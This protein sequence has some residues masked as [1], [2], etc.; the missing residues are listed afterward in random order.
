MS[1]SFSPHH[2][3]QSFSKDGE[4]NIISGQRRREGRSKR[5]GTGLE[6]AY[7]VQDLHRINKVSADVLAQIR[8]FL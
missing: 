8:Y 4:N 3:T 5:K 2:S 6:S 1:E 7:L